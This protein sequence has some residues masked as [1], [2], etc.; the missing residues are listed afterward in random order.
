ME[1]L[2]EW[3]VQGNILQWHSDL[4][5]NTPFKCFRTQLLHEDGTGATAATCSLT[6][7]V[8]Y[9]F[10]FPEVFYKVEIYFRVNSLC[11]LILRFQ[12]L[13]QSNLSSQR[14]FTFYFNLTTLLTI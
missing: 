2:T 7:R 6:Q 8:K 13:S 14:K 1:L 9:T 12:Y 3:N 5:K 10:N 11:V 4:D